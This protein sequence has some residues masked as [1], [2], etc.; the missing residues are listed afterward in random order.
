MISFIYYP[1]P[2]CNAFE[3]IDVYHFT[4]NESAYMRNK[5]IKPKSIKDPPTMD[6]P[7][8]EQIVRITIISQKISTKQKP[9]KSKLP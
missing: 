7:I 4:N 9:H 8:L 6:L 3:N 5:K 2:S 1:L